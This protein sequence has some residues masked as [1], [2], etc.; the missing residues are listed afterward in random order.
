MPKKLYQSVFDGIVQRI[1]GGGYA[2]GMMLPSEFEIA[3]EFGV[4]QGT[5]R[6]ALI[7]LEKKGIVERRQ[8]KGTFV[9]LRTPENSL[10]HF[11][12]LRDENG[13]Q[14]V[15]DLLD[16]KIRKREATTREH[17]RLFGQPE[18]VFEISR[19]RSFEQKPLCHELSVVSVSL[20][21]GLIE[22]AP[23]PNT[24]YVLFQQAY[25][26]AIISAR[27]KLTAKPAGAVIGAALGVDPEVSVIA[28][29]RESLDLLERVI[30]LRDSVYLTDNVH[31]SVVM[32]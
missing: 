2:P 27:D 31:Y 21:P 28:G 8:G 1:V 22:R 7:E 20:F 24:L 17:E 15:P 14:V 10:F 3:G 9:T 12:R 32:D 26:C 23:L 25:G 13:N 11:F 19:V 6:K 5:A 30:E 18:E 4:S 16:E 29:S